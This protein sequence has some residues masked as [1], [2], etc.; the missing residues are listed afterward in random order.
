MHQRCGFVDDLGW[1]EV[2][3]FRDELVIL[4]DD[5]VGVEIGVPGFSGA[6]AAGV[7]EES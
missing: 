2:D 7:A 4:D 5:S 6:N 1:S 3:R